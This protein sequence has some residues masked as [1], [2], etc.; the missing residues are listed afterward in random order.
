M[1]EG[2]IAEHMGQ[3]RNRK[4]AKEGKFIPAPELQMLREKPGAS[5]R[6]YIADAVFKH[7]CQQSRTGYG[8]ESRK[9]GMKCCRHLISRLQS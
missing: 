5:L 2:D 9:T 8:E 6:T 1:L 7:S 4:A 3:Y